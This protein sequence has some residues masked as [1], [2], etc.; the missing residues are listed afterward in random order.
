MQSGYF[1]DNLNNNKDTRPIRPDRI[2]G[3]NDRVVELLYGQKVR[4]GKVSD[5]R[6]KNREGGEGAGCRERKQRKERIFPGKFYP[7]KVP[8]E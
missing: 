2:L 3:K 7:K 6:E 1:G 4:K 8:I 5:G